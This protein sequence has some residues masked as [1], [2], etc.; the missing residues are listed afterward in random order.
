MYVPAV[1]VWTDIEI[2]HAGLLVPLGLQVIVPVNG[3]VKLDVL[4]EVTTEVKVM[5]SVLEPGQLFSG[6]ALM[7]TPF[8]VTAP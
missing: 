7:L 1:P 5:V 2:G 8:P 4:E 6:V 3:G